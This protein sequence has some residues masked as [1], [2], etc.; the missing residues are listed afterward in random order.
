MS[1]LIGLMLVCAVAASASGQV[2][3]HVPPW[4]RSAPT[5]VPGATGWQAASVVIA[6]NSGTTP[7]LVRAPLLPID[8]PFLAAPGEIVFTLE[9]GELEIRPGAVFLN[10]PIGANE[11]TEHIVVVAPSVD[12][13][14]PLPGIGFR[15]RPSS[16]FVVS[17]VTPVL[18]RRGLAGP[19]TVEFRVERISAGPSDTR[20]ISFAAVGPVGT[21]AAVNV[22][23]QPGG[24]T[25]IPVMVTP[26]PGAGATAVEFVDL[27]AIYS[28]DPATPGGPFP[29][30]AATIVLGPANTPNADL[31]GDGGVDGADLLLLLNNWTG[32]SK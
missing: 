23:L 17:P 25:V 7:R 11:T 32:S 29:H 13:V 14:G 12:G 20:T 8:G 2:V 9:P 27:I 28:D 1:R 22:M 5:L 21:P 30:A 15:A 10:T 26:D 31:N 18:D 3:V 16:Q 24:S 19:F 6:H 4:T